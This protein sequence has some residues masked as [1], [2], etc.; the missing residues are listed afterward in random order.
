VEADTR[1]PGGKGFT[2]LEALLQYVFNQTLAINGFGQFGHYLAVDAFTDPRCS[3]YATQKSVAQGLALSGSSYRQCYSWLGPNQPGINETDPSNPTACVPDP[4]G[5][6]PGFRG[7]KTTAC[8][9]SPT[10]ADTT[11]ANNAS[12][13]PPKPPKASTASG[14]STKTRSSTKSH[15]SLQSSLGQ[16]ASSLGGSG[17]SSTGSSSSGGSSGNQT[18][19]LLNYLLAP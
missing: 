7:P 12:S 11:R 9:L 10:S 19:Q 8:K 1:S 17:K 14:S 16:L 15:A 5:A 4:G 18:Q 6:P 3:P 13:S 2:G